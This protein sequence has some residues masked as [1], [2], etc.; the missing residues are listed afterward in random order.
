MHPMLFQSDSVDMFF[1]FVI[2]SVSPLSMFYHVYRM[3]GKS[4][5]DSSQGFN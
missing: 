2:A 1:E 3:L 4:Q 5:I